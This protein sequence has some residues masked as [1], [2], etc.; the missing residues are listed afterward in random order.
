VQNRMIH[1][2]CDRAVNLEQRPSSHYQ[3]AA[4][5]LRQNACPND[6]QI[7]S[8]S[9]GRSNYLSS[10]MLKIKAQEISKAVASEVSDCLNNTHS[11][12]E[13]IELIIQTRVMSLLNESNPKKRKSGEM[14]LED[15]VQSN[16][17]R[18]TCRICPKTVGRPCDLKK[19]EK[20]HSR[21]WGCTHANCSKSFGSKNDW[22]RHENSQHFQLETWRCNE[23]SAT[24]KINQCAKLSYRRDEFQD[25]LKVDHEIV[26]GAHIQERCK[27]SRI[28]RN[29]QGGFWCGFCKEIVKL[30]KRG[31]EAWDERFNHIDGHF[32]EEFSIANW[33]PVDKDVPKGLLKASNMH[34]NGGLYTT[35]DDSDSQHSDVDEPWRMGPRQ[36]RPPPPPP[37]PPPPSRP[38]NPPFDVSLSLA[39]AHKPHVASHHTTL[40]EQPEL[41]SRMN[42]TVQRVPEN[43]SKQIRRVWFCCECGAGPYNI[44]FIHSCLGD[45]CTHRA[46]SSCKREL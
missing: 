44:S 8:I 19:H 14:E 40:Q 38:P 30:E 33:Y 1:P 46:C 34:K 24:S 32:K 45:S 42:V 35:M 4:D 22:K 15:S 43:H 6:Q 27:K 23:P 25:H 3:V 26:D 20:R 7:H 10:P 21:P 17:K 9:K 2:N 31:S 28:G 37:P 11:S 29:G 18:I 13:D 41:K 39:I 5:S 12:Q 16:A 36:R